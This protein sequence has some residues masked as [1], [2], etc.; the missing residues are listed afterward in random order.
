MRTL[1]R[2]PT[3]RR[4][5]I[6]SIL[7]SILAGSLIV[8]GCAGVKSPTGPEILSATQ[9][10]DPNFQSCSPSDQM[11]QQD[12]DSG[13]CGLDGAE[14]RGG[15]DGAGGMGGG[16]DGTGG[17]GGGDDGAEGAGGSDDGAGGTGGSDNGGDIPWCPAQ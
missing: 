3:L 13:N 4:T 17:V 5:A 8:A 10:C 1:E 11:D 15:G 12:D 9:S 2:C 6:T 7:T 14:G 16:E